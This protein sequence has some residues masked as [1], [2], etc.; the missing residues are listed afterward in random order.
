MITSM[1]LEDL[2]PNDYNPNTMTKEEF[3]ELVAEIR[4]LGRLPKPVV[5]RPDGDGHVI[6]DGEQNWR[7]AREAGLAE[8]ACEV[9]A[10]D[11]FEAMRQTY[12]RN[13][14]GTHDPLLL[15]RMFRRML[16]ARGLS[17][18]ALAEEITVSEGTVRNALTYAEAADLRN[19]YAFEK[20]SV[21]QVRTYLRLP[22][23]LGD[24]WLDS[25]AALRSLFGTKT[26]EG[27][28]AAEYDDGRFGLGQEWRWKHYAEL[29]ASGLV[30]FLPKPHGADGFI[31]AMKTLEALDQWERQWLAGGRIAR[32]ELR[33]YTRH[34]FGGA[35]QV[36]ETSMIDSALACLID[37]KVRP[38]VFL[39]TPEEFEDLIVSNERD[40][41]SAFIDRLHVAVAKKTGKV[42]DTEWGR[43]QQ[44]REIELEQAPDWIRQSKLPFAEK[45]ALW[46]AKHWRRIVSEEQ[47]DSAEVLAIKRALAARDRLER[48]D[49]E[50]V[51]RAVMRL[52]EEGIQ[53]ARVAVQYAAMTG[54]E[55]ARWIA[56]HFPLYDPR[57]ERAEIDRLAANL[58]ALTKPELLLLREQLEAFQRHEALNLELAGSDVA[59]T[60]QRL[61]ALL[62]G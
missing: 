31:R 46:K 40:S 10:A 53:G 34:H 16:E 32:E 37:A 62:K 61:G 11:D 3:A 58:D 30:A 12:K 1:R 21:R 19:S 18:R 14:H 42:P 48:K 38:P 44:L 39:L 56:E 47:E 36:R 2:H 51:E 9:I 27:A 25:G 17:Q 29:E 54:N 8:V 35:W 55:L 59:G 52:I 6:V 60:I 43:K 7:A 26:E 28:A 15:G 41:F 45:Y 24:L 23:A 57:R 33:G 50:S 5:V 4:H 49:G 13:Q 20:L 22:R